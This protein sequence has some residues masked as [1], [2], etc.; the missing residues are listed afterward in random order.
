MFPAESREDAQT[1]Y[2]LFAGESGSYHSGRTTD[3]P[4]TPQSQLT[5]Y[6]SGLASVELEQFYDHCASLAEVDLGAE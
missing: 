1:N 2:E 3:F 6:G 5:H 4:P